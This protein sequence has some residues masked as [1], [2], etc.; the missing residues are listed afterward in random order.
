[1]TY[2]DDYFAGLYAGSDDPWGLA[3]EPY[4]HRKHAL[5]LAALPR[6]RYSRA[7][8]PGC[9][10]GVLTAQ[11]AARCDQLVSWDGADSAVVQAR[12]RVGQPHVRIEQALVPARWPAGSFDLVVVSE[13]LYFLRAPDRD[14]L[15]AA[16]GG[17]LRPGGHLIAV[18][19]RHWFAEATCTGDEAHAE[20]AAKAVALGLRRLVEHVETDFLLDVWE[21]ASAGQDER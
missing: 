18:H 6:M 14:G 13:L 8:E 1:V 5:T 4:E 19:W 2:F 20:V 17:C 9:A 12:E 3:T 21:A 10:I 16:V 11:L 15:A 7:F